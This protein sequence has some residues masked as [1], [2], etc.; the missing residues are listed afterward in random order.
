MDTDALP[1]IG[2]ERVLGESREL[3]LQVAE[4]AG[5]CVV[6]EGSAGIGKSRL[7]QEVEAE[8]HALGLGVISSQAVKLDKNTPLIT[9]RSLFRSCHLL[10]PQIPAGPELNTS[11]LWAVDQVGEMIAQQ[12]RKQPMLIALDD[13]HWADEATALALR[14]LVPALRSEPVLWYFTRRPYPIRSCAQEALDW[15]IGDGAQKRQLEPLSDGAVAQ[16]CAE[17]LGTEPDEATLAYAARSGGNPFLLR[18]MLRGLP[19][20]GPQE[21]P[22]AMTSTFFDAVGER[23]QDLPEDTRRALDAMTVFGRPFGVHE[24]AALLGR[25]AVDLLGT[26][27]MLV[28]A[29]VLVEQGAKLSFR[30]ELIREA[31]Y[32]RMPEPTRATL[33]QEAA[34]VL[35]QHGRSATEQVKHLLLSGGGW[36][37][38]ATVVKRA[39]QE[40]APA[41]PNTGADLIL[42]SLPLITERSPIRA[43]LA[44]EAVRLLVLAGRPAEAIELGQRFRGGGLPPNTEAMLLLGLTEALH[45]VGEHAAVIEHTVLALPRAKSDSMVRAELL[46]MHAHGLVSVGDIEPAA[47]AATNTVHVANRARTH[48]ALV[49]GTGARS[50]VSLAQGDIASAI[51]YGADAVRLGDRAGDIGRTRHPRLHL[52]AALTAADRLGEAEEELGRDEQDVAEL[53]TVWSQPPRYLCRAELL[54]ATGRLNDAAAEAEAGILLTEQLSAEALAVPLLA[55]RA[56]VALRADGVS[57]AWRHL[58]RAQEIV[59][60]GRRRMP[61]LLVWARLLAEGVEGDPDRIRLELVE[62]L[63]RL[64]RSRSLLVG[65]P[66]RI[67]VLVRLAMRVGADDAAAQVIAA[68]AELGRR[69]PDVHVL[70]G[71]AAHGA[72]LHRRDVRSLRTAVEHYRAGSQPVLLAHGLEDLAA[73]EAD[74]GNLDQ[75]TELLIEAESGYARCDALLDAARMRALLART[76][77]LPEPRRQ[78]TRKTGWG[79]LTR[80]ELRVVRLVAEGLTNRE[81]ANRLYLSPHTVDSH[82]RHSFAKLGITSRVE[83]AR[84]VM[85]HDQPATHANT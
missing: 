45:T 3:L 77:N 7:L 48:G 64:K 26:V 67:P 34:S 29:E 30:H 69:N 14:V 6:V 66:E 35:A 78:S 56:V 21:P 8:S 81:V 5:N 28:D 36:V 20:D 43:E 10:G 85:T 41:A 11:T 9:L 68:A 76:P 19:V 49:C 71:A 38:V 32:H 23:M 63:D 46:A 58:N 61:D 13:A 31:L 59:E 12:A 15:L 22:A 47:A 80:A 72:G 70:L 74:L 27:A 84:R 24:V 1:L 79:S 62:V 44:A 75:A 51:R 39:V 53:E 17:V 55:L 50:R 57:A 16:L 52:A 54:F 18:E 37:D 25:P 2:R 42:R 73:A 33:H 82:L 40:I 83:L 60:T 65:S 4:G